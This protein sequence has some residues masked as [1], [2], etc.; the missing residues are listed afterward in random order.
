MFLFFFTFPLSP[1]S[2]TLSFSFLLPSFL[3]PYLLV[4]SPPVGPHIGRYCGQTSPGR[5][6]SYTGIL[7][8]IITTDSAIAKEG[9]SANYT[10]RERS[11]PPG[12]EDEGEQLDGVEETSSSIRTGVIVTVWLAS[13]LSYRFIV[14]AL[15]HESSATLNRFQ[16]LRS[17]AEWA[18]WPLTSLL[19]GSRAE[20]AKI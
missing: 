5:V 13:S 1:H 8:M 19:Q 10:I 4:P 9:F 7:S 3:L 11:L 12:H 2:L 20:A 15:T 6:I 16:L 14:S 17:C 18:L